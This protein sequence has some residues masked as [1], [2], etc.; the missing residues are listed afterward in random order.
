MNWWRRFWSNPYRWG[1]W[2]WVGKR[3]WLYRTFVEITL[4]MLVS[5]LFLWFF[6]PESVK[7]FV[8]QESTQNLSACQA[9]QGLLEQCYPEAIT[10]LPPQ[11]W[12]YELLAY[13]FPAIFKNFII[14]VVCIQPLIF[15]VMMITI[16]TIYKKRV[17]YLINQ[18]KALAK[19]RKF[20]LEVFRKH[21]KI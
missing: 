11:R 5:V 6:P 9:F 2:H 13:I 1:L 19:T 10:L 18:S 12:V 3:Q 7:D 20:V 4:I 17:T 15:I 16:V 8:L 14:Y 21:K